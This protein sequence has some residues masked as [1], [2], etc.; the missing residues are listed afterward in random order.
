MGSPYNP[1]L[2]VLRHD[3]E[4]GYVMSTVKYSY[5]SQVWQLHPIVRV[6]I[7]ITLAT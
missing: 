2:S 3:D 1:P 7:L 4:E 5:G 6:H